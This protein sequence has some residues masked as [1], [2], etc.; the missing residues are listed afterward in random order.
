MLPTLPH[1]M[2][3]GRPLTAT[4][5]YLS[6]CVIGLYGSELSGGE[7]D[8]L[9]ASYVGHLRTMWKASC[10]CRSAGYPEGDIMELKQTWGEGGSCSGLPS[11]MDVP[12]M[13]QAVARESAAEVLRSLRQLAG[14]VRLDHPA[15]EDDII[16]L[17]SYAGGE[18]LQAELLLASAPSG[19]PPAAIPP[20]Q[21]E[22]L[23][24][25]TENPSQ[26]DLVAAHKAAIRRQPEMRDFTARQAV[27]QGGGEAPTAWSEALWCFNPACTNLEGPSELALKTFACG[28]GCGMRY[29]SPQCQAQGWRDGHRLS[30]GRLGH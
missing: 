4:L 12:T 24:G 25:I 22:I 16:D 19:G 11:P 6:L 7:T 15:G 20:G 29:C 1:F 23:E 3:Q 2:K 18:V 10:S 13:S 27:L 30:C 9:V 28:G 26:G 14:R 17:T 5:H 21:G 8:R